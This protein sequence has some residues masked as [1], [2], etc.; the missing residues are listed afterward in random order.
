MPVSFQNSLSGQ[1]LLL[2]GHEGSEC[3]GPVA[4]KYGKVSSAWEFVPQNKVAIIAEVERFLKQEE[5]E[6][7]S[8]ELLPNYSVSIPD[9]TAFILTS[10]SANMQQRLSYTHVQ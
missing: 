7:I 6:L 3:H 5:K 1:V 9:Q 2:Q 4:C 8:G 10:Q